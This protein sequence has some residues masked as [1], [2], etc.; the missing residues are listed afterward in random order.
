MRIVLDPPELRGFAQQLDALSARAELE[1]GQTAA[2]PTMPPDAAARV[3]DLL[4]QVRANERT[5]GEETRSIALELRARALAAELGVP[6]RT[7][8]RA[9]GAGLGGRV[10]GPGFWGR[11]S[12]F[13]D[14]PL[15]QGEHVFDTVNGL[16]TDGADSAMIL[17]LRG[18][19][20]GDVDELGQ[21]VLEGGPDS[22]SALRALFQLRQRISPFLPPGEDEAT[23]E[24]L[25]AGGTRTG[26]ALDRIGEGVLPAALGDARLA[27]FTKYMGDVGDVLA[28]V[29]FLGDAVTVFGPS[30]PHHGSTWNNVNRGMAVVNAVGI[31]AM[32]TPIGPPL[33]LA[34][35]AWDAGNLIYA[36]RQQI[37]HAAVTV[38]ADIWNGGSAVAHAGGEAAHHAISDVEHASSSVAHHLN[39]FNW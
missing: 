30:D 28:P 17:L 6:L 8:L 27:K 19:I 20:L 7:L 22:A 18:Q 24:E 38:S 21:A 15:M 12:H 11:L 4:S 37:A 39:P 36:H 14:S 29:A 13:F 10:N 9:L 35:G 25:L 16:L 5:V 1:L 34:T 2:L 33:L 32:A 3:A 26:S 23:L 31:V